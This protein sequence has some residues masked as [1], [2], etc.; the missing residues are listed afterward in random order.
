M[1]RHVEVG[2]LKRQHSEERGFA[3]GAKV[4]R[5]CI[6]QERSGDR[7]ITASKCLSSRANNIL[8]IAIDRTVGAWLSSVTFDLLPSAFV[9]S[10]G[11]AAAF[12]GGSGRFRRLRRA[13]CINTWTVILLALCLQLIV[14][15]VRYVDI[16]VLG[17]RSIVNRLVLHGKRSQ[18]DKTVKDLLCWTRTVKGLIQQTRVFVS[19][20]SS[21]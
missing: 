18:A 10:S 21:V 6:L 12:Q 3:F 15:L 16:D 19:P 13:R 2:P 20:G 9:A 4:D 7:S 1:L 17:R 11:Y 14:R 8:T 5:R